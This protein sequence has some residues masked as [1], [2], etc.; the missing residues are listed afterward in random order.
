MSITWRDVAAERSKRKQ[1][2]TRLRELEAR[3]KARIDATG[4]LSLSLTLSSYNRALST[5]K[6]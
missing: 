5:I 4:L 2:E 1:V 6:P 3:E